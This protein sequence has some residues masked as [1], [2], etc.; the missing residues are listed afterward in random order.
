MQNG[1]NGGAKRH[2]SHCET[3]RL[4]NRPSNSGFTPWARGQN[5][6]GPAK[7]NGRQTTA[8]KVRNRLT[9][10]NINQNKEINHINMKT[11]KLLV[12][13]IAT[14]C[15]PATATMSLAKKKAEMT[16]YLFA[17]FTGNAPEQEQICFAISDYGF[18]YTPLNG[19]RPIISSDTIALSKGVRD[20]HILRADDGTFYMVATDM[21][22]SLGWTSNR[23]I[24][25]MKSNDLIHWEHHTVHFPERFK[26]TEFA[27]VTRVWA[28]Q[29]IYDKSA[30]KYMVYFSLLTDDKSIPYDKVYY[31][32]A[33]PDFSGLEGTPK[34]LFDYKEATIDTDI[35]EDE[36]GTYHLFFKTEKAGQHKGIRKYTFTDLHSPDTWKLRPGFCEI[37]KSDVEGSC[38]FPL[39][40]GGWCLMYDCY[41]DHNYQFAKSSDLNTFEYVQDSETRGAFT[42]RHGTTIQITKK[43]RKRLVKAFPINNK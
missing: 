30:G 13:L 20:P 36:N 24:V 31:C 5:R 38:V 3:G 39:I 34:V 19:G 28:P 18:N 1:M 6:H 14:L 29:T 25:L 27:N 40:Q 8:R 10:S 21:R 41:R 26:G 12:A 42:P 32:Y 22:C 11:R 37:T 35:V 15:F 7:A 16:S 23:G 33:T 9:T 2:V 17:Y 4:T 43:E